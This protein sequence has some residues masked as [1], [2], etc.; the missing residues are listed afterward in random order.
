[1]GSF[2]GLKLGGWT[3]GP[4][5]DRWRWEFPCPE[6]SL[7]AAPMGVPQKP[8][9]LGQPGPRLTAPGAGPDQSSH[10]LERG[11]RSGEEAEWG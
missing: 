3:V 4:G 6:L 10:L 9:P 11:L 7:F 1:M 5:L 2:P 8:S